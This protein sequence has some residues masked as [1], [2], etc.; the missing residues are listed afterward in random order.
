MHNYLLALVILLVSGCGVMRSLPFTEDSKNYQAAKRSFEQGRYD[1]ARDAY[2]AIA[3]TRSPWAEEAKFNAASVL[4][5]YDNPQKSYLS[6]EGEF[7]DFL[8]RYP[9]SA[10]ASEASTWLAML[11]MFHQTNVGILSKEVELLTVK[12]ERLTKELQQSQ[13]EGASLRKEREMILAEKTL[14]LRKVEYLLGEK[15]A[16]IRKKEELAND[17]E[18]LV[19]DKQVLTKRVEVLKKEKKALAEAKAVLEK[20]LRDLT[21]V[22]VKMERKRSKIKAEEKK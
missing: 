12:G 10:L 11:K 3:E 2:R 17:N 9:Q 4:V 18:A 1:A 21:M 22:D 5:Y 13:S 7:E 15:E 8:A 6:A 19:K 14:L 20:S 16:L